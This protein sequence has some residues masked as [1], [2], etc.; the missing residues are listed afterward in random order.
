MDVIEDKSKYKQLNKLGLTFKEIKK[1]ITVEVGV[2]FLL[3]YIVAVIHFCFAINALKYS[4]D[5][6][7]ASVALQII[8]AMFF[9]QAIYFLVIKKNYLVEIKRELI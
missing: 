6:P 5:I 3:P 1:I 8:G 9:I 2:L 7:I 4:F